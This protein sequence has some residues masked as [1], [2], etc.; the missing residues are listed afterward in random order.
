VGV[1]VAGIDYS[2][3]FIDVVLVPMEGNA[4]PVWHRFVLSG[5]DAFDR[6]RSVADAM[7]GRAS[8]FWDNVVGA[9]IEHPGG[10]HG[11]RDMLRVQGAILSCL[12]NRLLVEPWP[13]AKWR[14][15]VGLP[16]NAS[17][18]LVKL[19]SFEH[20][21][22]GARYIDQRGK[23]MYP[24]WVDE[25]HHAWPQDAHDAHLIALAARQAITTEKAA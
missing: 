16:G 9:G 1:T 5:T 11:T 7:P 14:A 6:T 23:P 18:G 13:P 3:R 25:L 4:P 21:L 20:V 24:G 8:V 19:G 2:S 17:K 22:L 15:A 12:P 10:H